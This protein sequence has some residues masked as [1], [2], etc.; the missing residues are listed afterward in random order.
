MLKVLFV[1][2]VGNIIPA[3]VCT[4][5]N[6]TQSVNVVSRYMTNPTKR[7]WKTVKWILRC[8][9]GDFD[10]S[11]TF[12]K[13]EGISVLDYVNSDNEGD[14]DR[15]KSTTEYIFTLIGSVVS[16]KLI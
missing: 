10:V 14:L 6:I 4:H 13:N 7:H 16:W 15:R 5:L 8:L 2:A 1:R 12:Q 11:L 3:M 9:K